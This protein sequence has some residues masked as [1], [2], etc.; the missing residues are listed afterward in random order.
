MP[1]VRRRLLLLV[2]VCGG[3]VYG[4]LY[5]FAFRPEG[6]LI[7][8]LRH[9]AWA[10][11]RGGRGD[12]FAN[13]LLFLPFGLAATAALPGRWTSGLRILAAGLAGMLLSAAVELAQFW[14]PQRSSSLWDVGFNTMGALAG[15]AL[16]AFAGMWR[17]RSLTAHGTPRIVEPLAGLLALAWLGYRFYPYVP[18]IDLQAWKDNLKP[19]LLAGG[20]PDP[21]R[22]LRLAVSWT[23]AALLAEAAMSWR[24]A[25]WA[26]PFGLA[27]AVVVEIVVPGKHLTPEEALAI[28]LAI[29]AWLLL[30]R[31]GRHW[32]GVAMVALLLVAVGIERL[33][34]FRFL[35]EAR[36]FGWVPFNSLISGSWDAGLQAMLQKLF[37]Y[38]ALLWSL[39]RARLSLPLATGAAALSVL[40]LSLIQTRLPGRSAESTDALLVL[41]LGFVFHL[42]PARQPADGAS[43][44]M[45]S[46]AAPPAYTRSRNAP[47]PF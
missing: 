1:E 23:A 26:V 7:E 11:R 19:L 43:M 38:G 40:A 30:R 34:P 5:P 25:A 9:G 36:R 32:S 2:L 37:L 4:T 46:E 15:A 39:R 47:T 44:R 31:A 35:P 3:I 42:M 28:G 45:A 27:G 17:G 14:I 21:L 16:A 18:A 20:A 29:P 6:T 22:L 41:G 33:E 24:T 13:L 10:A 8:A 12:I